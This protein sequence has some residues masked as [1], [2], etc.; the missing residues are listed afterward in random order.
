L[1]RQEIDNYLKYSI[2]NRAKTKKKKQCSEFWIRLKLS[3]RN[4]RFQSV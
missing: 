1:H 3:C 4:Q 2:S